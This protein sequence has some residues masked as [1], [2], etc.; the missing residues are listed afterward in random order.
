MNKFYEI[1]KAYTVGSISMEEA[2]ELFTSN[3]LGGRISFGRNG[4]KC[5]TDDNRKATFVNLEDGT[6]RGFAMV[7]VGIGCMEKMEV[8]DGKLKYGI[9]DAAEHTGFIGGHS[10]KIIDGET[11]IFD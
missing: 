1:M 3:K 11:L 5:L 2:N 6:C 10:F 9:G 7:D 4:N 8:V